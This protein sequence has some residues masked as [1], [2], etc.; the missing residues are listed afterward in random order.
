VAVLLP[1]IAAAEA[2]KPLERP[3]SDIVAKLGFD[4]FMFGMRARP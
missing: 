2:G 1:M 4:R 3:L